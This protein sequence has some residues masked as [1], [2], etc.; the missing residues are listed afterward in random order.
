MEE[1][2]HGL[3]IWIDATEVRPLLQVAAMAGPGNIVWI[4]LAPMLAR[5][6]VFQMKRLQ[7]WTPIGQVTVL[8]APTCAL[9]R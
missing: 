1:W 2:N 7:G 4:G 3:S 9:L 5:R 6:N 8:T